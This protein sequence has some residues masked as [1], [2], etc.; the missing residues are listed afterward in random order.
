MVEGC[1]SCRTLSTHPRREKRASHHPQ[2]T[3]AF[4]PRR[5]PRLPGPAAST[6]PEQQTRT[7]D[8]SNTR[9]RRLTRRRSRR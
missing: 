2:H 5:D 6:A 1:C 9:R 4:H 3:H 8:A 7:H